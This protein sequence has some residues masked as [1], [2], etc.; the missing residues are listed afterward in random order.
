MKRRI[1]AVLLAA[2]TVLTSV[3]AY[4][5]E[6]V[7]AMGEN[8]VMQLEFEGNVADSIASERQTVVKKWSG[9][10][11]INAQEGTDYQFVEGIIGEKALQLNG[12]SYLSLGAEADLNPS[13]L[14]FSCWINPQEKMTGEQILV[15]NK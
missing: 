5:A 13:N 1:L 9:D 11:S 8:C 12:G 3:P 14:T 2:A 4:A 6:P 15:W 10:E 7:E